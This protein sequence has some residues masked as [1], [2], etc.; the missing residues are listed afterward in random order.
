MENNIKLVCLTSGK[1]KDGSG[2]WFRA[3]FLAHK[4]DNSPITR[5]EFLNAKIGEKMIAEGLV[6]DAPVNVE[7]GYDEYLR[8]VVVNVTKATNRSASSK[9]V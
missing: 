5:E 6:E 3:T 7:L 9:E 2:N 4:P 8:P 1:K